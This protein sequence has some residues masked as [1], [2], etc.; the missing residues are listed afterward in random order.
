MLRHHMVVIPLLGRRAK[1]LPELVDVGALFLA[2]ALVFNQND[3]AVGGA[4][5]D[6]RSALAGPSVVG[7]LAFTR[8]HSWQIRAA[9]LQEA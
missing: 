5:V 6:G 4:Q 1:A 9:F 2:G 7:Q 3:F 8:L